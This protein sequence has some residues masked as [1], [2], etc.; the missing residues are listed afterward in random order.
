M[1]ARDAQNVVVTG[2]VKGNLATTSYG[3][4]TTNKTTASSRPMS[5]AQRSIVLQ[6][7]G[8][9][10]PTLSADFRNQTLGI[11]PAG[12]LITNVFAY[13]DT[14]AVISLQFEDSEET[15][16]PAV[17]IAL[18]PSAD[19]WDVSRAE[20]ISVEY[21]TQVIGTIAAGDTATVIVEFLQTEAPAVGGVLAKAGDTASEDL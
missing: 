3:P 7:D 2:G 12:S 11:I 18:T 8:D 10:S 14:G 13:S 20:D 9:Q 1:S 16:L 17:A 21:P 6:L 4:R 15:V 5:W 19:G